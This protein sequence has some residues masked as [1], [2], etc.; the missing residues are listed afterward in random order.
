MTHFTCTVA[1]PGHIEPDGVRIA[2]EYALSPFNEVLEI[3]HETDDDGDTFSYN[4]DGHWDWWVVGGRW[5]GHWVL[6]DSALVEDFLRETEPSA[7]GMTETA[8]ELDRSDCARLRAICP[9]SLHPAYAF[10]DLNG[11]W[12]ETGHICW[13]GI[14]TGEKSAE[15]WADE[16]LRWI[17]SLPDDTW[18][19]NCDLHA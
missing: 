14:A 7:F 12:N 9:E 17:A 11:N 10:V 1:L 16:Y 13:F 4:P 19:V 3:E 6:K 2:L 18:L 8:L 15:E 5:G